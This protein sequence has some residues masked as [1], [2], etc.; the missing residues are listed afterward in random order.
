M[1]NQFD[2]SADKEDRIKDIERI[3]QCINEGIDNALK[4]LNNGSNHDGGWQIHKSLL[5][6]I[7]QTAKSERDRQIRIQS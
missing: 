4:D 5:T 3:R 7:L 1:A 6:G 2:L